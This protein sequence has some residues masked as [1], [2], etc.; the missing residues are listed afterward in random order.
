MKSTKKR[1]IVEV[2]ADVSLQNAKRLL[3]DSGLKFW[4][5]IDRYLV[6]EATATQVKKFRAR[7]P[8][9]KVYLDQG[10][11]FFSPAMK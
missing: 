2:P 6:V 4:E 3:I 11:E 7:H 1:Y 10:P 5:C 9:F 8:N